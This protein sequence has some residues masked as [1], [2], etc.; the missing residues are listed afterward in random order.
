MATTVDQLLIKIQADTQDLRNQLKKVEQQTSNSS[1]KMQ[2]SL[3]NVETSFD[4]IRKVAR[5]LGPVI[6]G[7]FAVSALRGI[8]RTG[9]EAENL[10]VRLNALFQSAEEGGKAF[11]IMNEFASTVPFSLDQI[12]A[13]S[14]NLG[15][16]TKDADE[17]KAMLGIVANT[18]S[19]TGL[20][21][22]TTAEQ[23]QRSFSTGI[24]SADL[25]RER[26]VTAFLK[27]EEGGKRGAKET[28]D[29]FIQAFGPGGPFSGAS[30]N[31]AK[32]FTGAVS[33]LGDAIFNF[34]K[35]IAESGVNDAMLELVNVLKESGVFSK[36]LART[37]G[38]ALGSAIRGF[39]EAIK[40]AV[41]NMKSLLVA[42]GAFVAV[43]TVMGVVN[44]ATAMLAFSK[45]V[46]ASKSAMLVLNSAIKRTPLGLLAAGLAFLAHKSGILDEVIE[47]VTK[48]LDEAFGS[49][50][51]K[52]L[53]DNTGDVAK[54]LDTLTKRLE[55]VGDKSKSK[56]VKG[57]ESLKLKAKELQFILAGANKEFASNLFSAGGAGNVVGNQLQLTPAIG[58]STKDKLSK[59]QIEDIEKYTKAI[60]ELQ[61]KLDR[62]DDAVQLVTDIE[63]DLKTDRDIAIEQLA[64]IKEAY[65]AGKISVTQFT[66]AQKELSKQLDDLQPFMEKVEEASERMGNA[67]AD[68][69]ADALVEGELSLDS[70]KDIFKS[71][72]KELIAEAIR[73]YVIKQ[74]LASVFGGAGGG[75][76]PANAPIGDATAGGGKI[77]SRANGGYMPHTRLPVLVGE[78]GPEL[79]MPNTGG[80]IK[81]QMD[82]M[83]MMQGGGGTTVHQN[84]N[85]ETGVQ[86]TVRAE[87]VNLMPMIKKETMNAVADAKQ[88]GGSFGQQMGSR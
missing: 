58:G 26:G 63:N 84:I 88:R 49:D 10:R 81:N 74:I 29:A 21:F 45:A 24:A 25:F 6:A 62:Y 80:T 64:L 87:I 14:G 44:I 18:A 20:D 11:E 69:L 57:I 54:G 2:K 7:A 53:T 46:V 42:I 85:V 27:F 66:V 12:M 32:T 35:T 51:T 9:A 36:D 15:A 4:G 79:F 34:Q 82:A 30:D 17:L 75:N 73:M 43:K 1:Q 22:K 60:S 19:L 61:K 50:S 68:S 52:E 56:A 41:E 31:L 86:N 28:A 40:F 37:I 48:K 71:F 13:A 77:N 70:F 72:V 83:R 78:R 8:I 55:N 5:L 23:I 33:M 3:R 39:T 47:S 65:D 76:V 67:I 38:R 16:V 59:Q